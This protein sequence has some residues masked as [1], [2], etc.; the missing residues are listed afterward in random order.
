[1]PRKVRVATTA[2]RPGGPPRTAEGNTLV[3]E[4]L[5]ERAAAIQPDIIRLP[6]SFSVIGVDKDPAEPNG[7]TA[8]TPGCA[9]PPARRR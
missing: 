3:A 7:R 5:L 4:R 8:A 2:L 9:S 6:Q 1:M